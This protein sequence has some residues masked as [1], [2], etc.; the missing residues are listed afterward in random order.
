MRYGVKRKHTGRRTEV[1]VIGD[2]GE[3]HWSTDEKA[4]TL[5]NAETKARNVM[6]AQCKATDTKNEETGETIPADNAEV[7]GVKEPG[8]K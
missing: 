3:V 7:F 1:M 6:A 2:R 5:W 8:E 4:A